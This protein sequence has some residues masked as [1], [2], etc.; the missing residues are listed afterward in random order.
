MRILQSKN[1]LALGFG[2][3]ILT[4]GKHL[5]MSR[6]QE[7]KRSG[8]LGVRSVDSVDARTREERLGERS[9]KLCIDAHFNHIS[10]RQL[11][12]FGSHVFP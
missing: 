8:L 5:Y 2:D 11:K 1:Y 3:D 4:N 12:I 9:S 7:A 6:R 10:N